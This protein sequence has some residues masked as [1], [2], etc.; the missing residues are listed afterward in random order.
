MGLLRRECIRPDY[1]ITVYLFPT[2]ILDCTIV[3]RISTE[4]KMFALRARQAIQQ[5]SLLQRQ[6]G[7][8]AVVANKVAD[9]IQKLF[10]DKLAEYKTKSASGKV[11][12]SA[13]LQKELSNELNRV[14]RIYGGGEGV[15]M[16]KFPEF[17]FTEPTVDPISMQ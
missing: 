2:A 3:L 17:T 15:D 9:P 14:S 1:T 6:F 10:L 11:V 12:P 16:T 4:S 8:S 5:S 7:I 13:E